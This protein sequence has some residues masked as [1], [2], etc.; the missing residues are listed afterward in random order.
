MVVDIKIVR[1]DSSHIV[2]CSRFVLK[3]VCGGSRGTHDDQHPPSC[4]QLPSTASLSPATL[5]RAA[6]SSSTIAVNLARFFVTD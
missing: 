5:R 3:P 1:E 4:T 6:H 2:A